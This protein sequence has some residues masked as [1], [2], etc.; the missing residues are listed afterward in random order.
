MEFWTQLSRVY[1]PLP[2][3]T[4]RSTDAEMVITCHEMLHYGLGEDGQ[5]VN[6]EVNDE[7]FKNW[8][9]ISFSR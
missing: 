3:L 1:L 2:I 8:L 7:G 4:L 9:H 5:L 6:M